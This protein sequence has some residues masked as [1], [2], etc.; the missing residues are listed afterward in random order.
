VE[1]WKKGFYAVCAAEIL[2]IAGFNASMP[3]IPF[4]IQDLGVKDIKSVNL[5][6]GA[7]STGV[8]I[9]LA[10]FA[11]IWGR[12]ADSH[13]KR[14]MLLRAAF[15]GAV[16]VALMGV[17]AHPWQLLALRTIQGALSGTVTAATLIVATMSPPENVGW[18]LGL[19]TTSVFIGSSIGPAIGG[20]VSD[21][22][23]YRLNFFV[24]SGFLLAAAF[25][26]IRFVP[27]D[28][29]HVPLTGPFWR[30]IVP[31][32]SYLAK[33]RPLAIL[34][35]L[36]AVLQLA[37]SIVGPILPLYIQSLTPNAARVGAT[38][39]LILGVS[40][41]S[42]ALSAAGLGRVSYKIGYERT[43]HICLG[44]A[45][46]LILPQAFVR[47]PLQLLV[48]RVIGAAFA[49]GTS[50]VINALIAVRADKTRQGTVYG[51]ASSINSTG[52]AAG[53]MVG[54]AIAA[55]LGYPYAFLATAG[56]L[57]ATV[58]AARAMIRAPVDPRA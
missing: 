50:P 58:I 27:K 12:L 14:L 5:W 28:S 15:G 26:V 19:L 29:P 37:N 57:L 43:L 35:A 41:L 32:F 30:R 38:T 16:S 11:P 3:I 24:T 36:S 55:G 17:V 39:G 31:D 22:F 46:L 20:I 33:S 6:V 52:M 4:Y 48:L 34:I 54:A 45:F 44:G 47:T 9:S 40:A 42:A 49:G 1:S 8:A 7:C 18:S 23:G 13:G 21:L 53:P 10:I 25:I 51:L 2:A 56:I